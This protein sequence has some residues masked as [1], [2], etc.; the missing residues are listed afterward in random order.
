MDA[1]T[2]VVGLPWCTTRVCT[3]CVLGWSLIIG[4]FLVG[5]GGNR[6][7][8]PL[9]VVSLSSTP[10]AGKESSIT[11]AMPYGVFIA[12]RCDRLVR[13]GA[14]WPWISESLPWGMGGAAVWGCWRRKP[15]GPSIVDEQLRSERSVPVRHCTWVVQ[16]VIKA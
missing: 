7:C 1:W 12:V 15:S 16:S 5:D 8:P 2:G 14:G 9:A 6:C 4:Q 3:G 11:F 10:I 13:L